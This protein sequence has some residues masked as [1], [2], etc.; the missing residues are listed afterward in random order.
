MAD[1]GAEELGV[2]RHG[3]VV[4]LA[5]ALIQAV[6]ERL[7]EGAHLNGTKKKKNMNVGQ[8][9]APRELSLIHI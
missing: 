9:G 4:D 7:V 6:G 5:R 2:G 8:Q 3:V 1:L